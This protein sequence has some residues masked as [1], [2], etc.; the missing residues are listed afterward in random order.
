MINDKPYVILTIDD[1]RTVRSSFRYFLEDYDFEVIE[2][3]RGAIG[4]EL[5]MQYKPDL[6]LLDLLMPEMDGL[7][8][9]EKI[10]EISPQTPVIVISGT[11]SISDVVEALRLG[12]CDYL[13]KPIEDLSV[14][15][16]S[17]NSALERTRL[18]RE[19]QSYRE[20]LEEKVTQITQKIRQANEELKNEI[21][22]R[23]EIEKSLRKS[24]KRFKMIFQD[25]PSNLMLTNADGEIIDCNKHFL[26]WMGESLEQVKLHN[27]NEFYANPAVRKEILKE[28]EQ[29]G[30]VY[31]KQV[32]FRRLTGEKFCGIISINTVTF[33]G[34]P[35]M[36]S[37]IFDLCDQIL[38]LKE[39]SNSADK[40]GL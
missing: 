30:S 34:K 14:L 13:L 28:L 31:Q 36:L 19:N 39:N 27:A 5:F 24:E 8:V 9:L 21:A 16:H 11:K 33:E 15:L 25:M 2:A 12:A 6:V 4:L 1:V 7:S 37:T 26:N 17:V 38:K 35:C 22:T 40:H 3:D 29:N 10:T 18:R 23:K 20:H 32:K